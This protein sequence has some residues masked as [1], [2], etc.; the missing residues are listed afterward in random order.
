MGMPISETGHYQAWGGMHHPTWRPR[1]KMRSEA[2]GKLW[3]NGRHLSAEKKTCVNSWGI[4]GAP[5]E[6]GY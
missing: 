6:K 2:K 5:T 3:R 1:G 4:I